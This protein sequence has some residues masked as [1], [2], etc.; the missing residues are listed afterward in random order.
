MKNFNSTKFILKAKKKRNSG[1]HYFVGYFEVAGNVISVTISVGE[2]GQV[3]Y[4]SDKGGGQPFIY[5][6][7][8]NWGRAQQKNIGSGYQYNKKSI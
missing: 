5:A 4:T 7:A 1:G 6:S 8:S 3:I 2:N